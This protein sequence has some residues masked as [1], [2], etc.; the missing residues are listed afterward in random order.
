MREERRREGE[1]GGWGGE[2]EGIEGGGHRGREDK[3]GQERPEREEHVIVLEAYR[4]SA[5]AS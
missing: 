1:R 3:R 4:Y 5:L 2:E